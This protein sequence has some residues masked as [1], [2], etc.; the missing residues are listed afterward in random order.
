M[1]LHSLLKKEK[2]RVLLFDVFHRFYMEGY[3]IYRLEAFADTYR[4]VTGELI[5]SSLSMCLRS[6]EEPDL[7]AH[8]IRKG[9]KRIRA[10]FRLFRQA[11]GEATCLRSVEHFRTL[12]GL[13]AEIRLSKVHTDTLYAISLDKRLNV[14]PGDMK[15]LIRK[16]RQRHK[17]ILSAAIQKKQLFHHV[18]SLLTAEL[19]HAETHPVSDC[20][21]GMLAEN[22]RK[23]YRNGKADLDIMLNQYSPENLHS[24]RKKVKCL[25]N[26]MILIRPIWPSAMGMMIHNLDLLAERLG[27]EHDLDE[28]DLY[29]SRDLQNRKIPVPFQLTDYISLK[30]KHLLKNIIPMAKRLFSEKPGALFGRLN[31]YYLVWKGM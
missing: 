9:T 11:T 27:N 14:D 18:G 7:A 8:E 1:L 3:R 17:R 23:T 28:L 4:R 25:W 2:L 30:R 22:I 31:T 15:R 6:D 16:L 10:V 24:L 29:L 21:F 5:R 20:E 12:S 19:D 13:L 26:Q